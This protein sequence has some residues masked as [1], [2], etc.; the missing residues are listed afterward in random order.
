ME[1]IVHEIQLPSG[2]VLKEPQ[3]MIKLF[4]GMEYL[5]YDAAEIRQDNNLR[6]QDMRAANLLNARMR[7]T[8]QDALFRKRGSINE[9]LT[10][11]PSNLDLSKAGEDSP[12][13]QNILKLLAGMCAVHYVGMPFHP[14]PV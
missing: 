7:Q 8:A 14:R 1:P 2:L 6:N 4:M 13:W 3:L 5:R 11:V 10:Q 12:V 9:V